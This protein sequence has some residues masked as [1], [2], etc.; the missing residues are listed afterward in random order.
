MGRTMEK[1]KALRELGLSIPVAIREAIG[2]SIN[3]F[4][5][6]N[7][8]NPT[9]VSETI[10]GARRPTEK[11]LTALISELGGTEDEWRELLWLAGKPVPSSTT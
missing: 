10:N 3:D 4:A 1:V 2:K 8:I 5:A 11:I 7:D 9:T 6:A